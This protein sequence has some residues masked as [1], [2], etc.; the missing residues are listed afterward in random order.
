MADGIGHRVDLAITQRLRLFRAF[1]FGGKS[2]IAS[3]HADGFDDDF[4]CG[5]LT[6][7][8]VADVDLLAPQAFKGIDA[9]AF[10]DDQS[11]RLWLDRK[12]RAQA[13][14]GAMVRKF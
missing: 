6:W 9:L 11:E 1:D 2:E 13:F 10:A 3:A 5:A 14:K 12:N 7:F 4:L 8:R